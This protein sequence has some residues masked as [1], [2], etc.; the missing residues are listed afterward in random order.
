MLCSGPTV[1]ERWAM[2]RLLNEQ[3]LKLHRDFLSKNR[4]DL[5]AARGLDLDLNLA[6]LSLPGFDGP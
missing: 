4:E 1:D 5:V 6:D 2:R 3:K